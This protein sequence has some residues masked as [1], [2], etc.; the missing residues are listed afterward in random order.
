MINA[1]NKLPLSIKL[2]FFVKLSLHLPELVIQ[3]NILLIKNYKNWYF[4]LISWLISQQ[5]FR[6]STFYT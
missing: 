2:Y 3:M 1:F 4:S 5:H 6:K